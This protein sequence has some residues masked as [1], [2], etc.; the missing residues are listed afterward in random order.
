MWNYFCNTIKN[1]YTL[2]FD[3]LFKKTDFISDMRTILNVVKERYG[4]NIDLEFTC[5][6]YTPEDYKICLVQC[7]P[8]QVN[9]HDIMGVHIPEIKNKQIVLKAEG[10][11]VGQSSSVDIET[12]I[13]ID[14]KTYGQ[15]S[16]SKR[17]IVARIIGKLLKLDKR[18]TILI[19]PGRW[20]TSTP[21]LGVPVTFAEIRK[22]HAI[23]EIDSMHEG[24]IPDLSLGTHFF[25]EMIET[26]MVYMGYFNSKENNVISREFFKE[27]KNILLDLLPDKTQWSNIVHIIHC[28]IKNE[29]IKLVADPLD[30]IGILYKTPLGKSK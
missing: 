5:N 3:K 27:P 15:L 24:L 18:K 30:Q 29:S 6:F 1:H 4:S 28:P 9:E 2:T 23:C 11:I 12:I 10:A 25:N 26:G 16:D 17:Y 13:Y 8:F 7:R 21:S 22:V 19:G 20:G 14:P